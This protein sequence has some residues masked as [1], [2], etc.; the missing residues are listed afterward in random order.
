M[1]GMVFFRSL[2]TSI[3]WQ[4][5]K[6]GFQNWGGGVTIFTCLVPGTKIVLVI[7][8]ILMF[9]VDTFQYKEISVRDK[10][11]G[12]PVA[13]RWCIVYAL[14][15]LIMLQLINQIGI[16]AGSFIYGQF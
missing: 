9:V 13:V 1:V 8:L 16:D 12:M 4:I 3:A 6:L 10:L 7:A 15:V 5:I 14:G 2:T 11:A